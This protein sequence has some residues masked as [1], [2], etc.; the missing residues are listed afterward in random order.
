MPRDRADP[1]SV[2]VDWEMIGQAALATVHDDRLAL[3]TKCR[4][5]TK[6][7]ATWANSKIKQSS[8][9]ALVV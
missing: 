3:A 5:E 8:P 9:Q 7:Q 1:S 4:A 2:L 6:R